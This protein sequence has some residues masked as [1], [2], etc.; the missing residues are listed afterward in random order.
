MRKRR[1]QAT[2]NKIKTLHNQNTRNESKQNINLRKTQSQRCTMKTKE[3][4]K[5]TKQQ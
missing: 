5:K 3:K 1:K 4:S 2:L